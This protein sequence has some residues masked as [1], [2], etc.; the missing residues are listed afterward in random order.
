MNRLHDAVNFQ[1]LVALSV[2]VVVVSVVGVS[3]S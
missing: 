2:V 1:S 3:A